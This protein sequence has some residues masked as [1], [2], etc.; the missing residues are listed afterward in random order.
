MSGEE[1]AWAAGFLEGE[2][3]FAFRG[4]RGS[5][6]TAE[7]RVGAA[8]VNREPLE[9]LQSMYG[10][11]IYGRT[12]VTQ[13]GANRRPWFGWELNDRS[14]VLRLTEDIRPWLSQNRL[15]RIPWIGTVQPSLP[16]A[17]WTVT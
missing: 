12:Q 3:W 1:I 16:E 4:S 11:K 2:G 10:G 6:P 17:S 9:R 13:D 7:M 15:D 8:Q 14:A 5:K